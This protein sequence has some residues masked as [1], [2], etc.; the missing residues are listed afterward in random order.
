MSK[1]QYACMQGKITIEVPDTVEDYDQ[2]G[3]RVGLCLEDAIK[4][5]VY[6]KTLGD[7][8]EEISDAVTKEYDFPRNEVD[9][10]RKR[11]SDNSAVMR[12]EDVEDHIKRFFVAKGWNWDNPPQEWLDFVAGIEV[13]FDP[14]AK[15]REGKAK[16][17]AKIYVAAVDKVYASGSQAKAA[18]VLG[19]TLT[20]DEAQ[21]RNLL[22][23]AIKAR[24][25]LK[26][27][28]QEAK[29]LDGLS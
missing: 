7:A 22:G 19:V 18:S 2:L 3:G 21:D 8:R 17:L 5:T 13:V 27:R 1:Q 10:G 6:H 4:K 12:D 16:N 24:E 26:R 28:E 23:W 14:S 11:K 9:T 20:G 25:D 15:V 29:I